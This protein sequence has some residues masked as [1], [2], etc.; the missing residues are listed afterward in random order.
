MQLHIGVS[1]L[2]LAIAA[3]VPARDSADNF[4]KF[5]SKSKS[6]PPLKLDDATFDEV[7][8]SPRD[9]SALLLLTAMP[10][11]FGCQLCRDFQPEFKILSRSWANGDK[12]GSTRLLFGSLDFPDG[13]ATF[14]KV[15]SRVSLLFVTPSAKRVP[16]MMLQTAPVLFFYPPTVGSHAKPD[17][18]P[19]RL[20]FSQG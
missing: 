18:Q 6:N 5:H 3:L 20:D 11:Q 2:L 14:Q 4:S 17:G 13:K 8:Q 9:Y 15:V 10:A 19:V 1:L 16:Q 12:T 7:T